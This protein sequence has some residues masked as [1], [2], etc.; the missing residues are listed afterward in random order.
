LKVDTV[1]ESVSFRN[2]FGFCSECFG[3]FRVTKA[4]K[5]HLSF[6]LMDG[7]IEIAVGCVG[8]LYL[9]NKFGSLIRY[10]ESYEQAERKSNALGPKQLLGIPAML[11]QALVEDGW[12]CRSELIWEKPNVRPDSCRDRCAVSHEQVF[13]LSR[14][15]KYYYDLDAVREP[16]TKPMNRWGGNEL[17]AD[18]VSEWD[19]GTGHGTYRDRDMRPNKA[20]RTKRTVWKIPT[21]P[22][23]WEFCW[24]CRTLFEGEDKKKISKK[25]EKMWCPVCE[26]SEHWVGHFAAFPDDLVEPCVKAGSGE[27]GCCPECRT[28][29]RRILKKTKKKGQAKDSGMRKE[30]HGPTYSRHRS[31]IPGGQSLVGYDY[32]TKGWEPG[33]QCEFEKAV[34]CTVFDPFV[35]SGTSGIVTRR[36][37]RNFF[38]VDL[39][40]Q[41]VAVANARIS[42]SGRR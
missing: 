22:S 2:A 40:E 20:G 8:H 26:S 21:K 25:D 32:E 7:A 18:G 36:L 1:N 35:G 17:K 14:S 4:S 5:E 31:S 39:N 27:M 24:N 34:P 10:A 3:D 11:R 33:C 6:S 38:G 42:R 37:G 19:K 15:P 28:P 29:L 41:Y 9:Q 12:I 13:L 30:L 16:Y 23:A